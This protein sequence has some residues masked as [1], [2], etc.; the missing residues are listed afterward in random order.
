MDRFSEEP[1]PDGR[2]DLARSTKGEGRDRQSSYDV[3]EGLAQ[4]V[5]GES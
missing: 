3:I 4:L 2:M 5:N 1:K